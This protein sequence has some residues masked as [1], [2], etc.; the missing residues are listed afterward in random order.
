MSYL[1]FRSLLHPHFIFTV[2]WVYLLPLG[3]VV[4]PQLPE[5]L[6]DSHGA[7]QAGMGGYYLLINGFLFIL[8]LVTMYLPQSRIR[9]PMSL[10]K[11]S[12]LLPEHKANLLLLAGLT[13]LGAEVVKELYSCNWSLHSW[14]E[15]SIGPRFGRPWSGGYEGGS[16]F[17]FTFIGN[18]FHLAAILLPFAVF[19][20]KG[21]R[22]IAAI[23]GLVFMF[24]ILICNGSRTP[25]AL[26]LL[27]FALLWYFMVSNP[28]VRLT[29]LLALAFMFVAMMALM[30]AFRQ[31]GFVAAGEE[32][33]SAFRQNG[34]VAAGEEDQNISKIKYKQ[35]DNYYRL[36]SVLK[37][38]EDGQSPT[39]DAPLFL[40]ASV[41]NPIPRYFWPGKPLLT[42]DFFGNWK[43]FYVTISYI[44]ECIAMFGKWLG[45]A[46]ALLLG[47]VYYQV[48]VWASR[49]LTQELGLLTYLGCCFYI[50]M[51]QRS[52]QNIGMEAVFMIAILAFYYWFGKPSKMIARP[53]RKRFPPQ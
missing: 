5:Y 16:D 29:G 48:L 9:I 1:R 51:I 8:F 42:E 52:I 7:S 38:A 39:W 19:Q 32:G 20:T 46:C 11:K 3:V 12:L 30:L 28:T 26:T 33:Q 45:L 41:M 2:S 49:L 40:K 47:L 27:M 36:I 43:L 34:F 14:F 23:A 37:V 6:Q 17:F 25:V 50:Y 22:R 21:A 24:G 18:L 4:S 13:I 53:K 10:V 31:N 35:D 44:G 15:F